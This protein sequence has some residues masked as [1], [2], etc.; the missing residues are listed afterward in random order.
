MKWEVVHPIPPLWEAEDR[1]RTNPTLDR[2]AGLLHRTMAR[3][4]HTDPHLAATLGATLRCTL[5]MVILMVVHRLTVDLMEDI[6]VGL[7]APAAAPVLVGRLLT[8]DHRVCTGDLLHQDTT[9]DHPLN[10]GMALSMILQASIE[11]G[12]P[13]SLELLE[14]DLPDPHEEVILPCHLA[15]ARR[16]LHPTRSM[17]LQVVVRPKLHLW[18]KAAANLHHQV[19]RNFRKWET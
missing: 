4:A 1:R 3:R 8:A 13:Q 9:D 2:P 16:R 15:R 5:I 7:M 10:T 12:H 17:D 11:V 18:L 6:P 19:P 14:A